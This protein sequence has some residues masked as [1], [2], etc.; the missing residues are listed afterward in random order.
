[1]GGGNNG[2]VGGRLAE[3]VAPE[4]ENTLGEGV[5]LSASHIAWLCKSYIYLR[6][7]PGSVDV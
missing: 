7:C 2:S 5:T 3:Q 4:Q 6:P 1:M